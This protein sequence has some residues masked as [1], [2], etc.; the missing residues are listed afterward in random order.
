MNVLF[1]VGEYCGLT[2]LLGFFA[3]VLWK[4]LSGT[5]PLD[6]LLE[7]VDERGQR[8]FSPGRAQLLIFTLLVAGRYLLAVIQNPNS[9]SLP[10]L[11]PEMLVVLGGSQAV[12]LGGKAWSAFVPLI[13]KLK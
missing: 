1:T 2:I 4:M 11:P 7:T 6:G 12:Y 3:I 5:I 13:K 10:A 9:N 8:S